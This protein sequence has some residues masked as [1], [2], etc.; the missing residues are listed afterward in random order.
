[1]VDLSKEKVL[2]SGCA[3]EGALTFVQKSIYCLILNYILIL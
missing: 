2:L 3:M 1:M